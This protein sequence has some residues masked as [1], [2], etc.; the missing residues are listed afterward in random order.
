MCEAGPPDPLEKDTPFHLQRATTRFSI[1]KYTL[2]VWCLIFR[3]PSIQLLW[4]STCPFYSR[5]CEKRHPGQPHIPV[6]S[7]IWVPPPTLGW[8]LNQGCNCSWLAANHTNN[9]KHLTMRINCLSLYKLNPFRHMFIGR[10]PGHRGHFPYL[11]MITKAVK[12]GHQFSIL[13]FQPDLIK[14]FKMKMIP[15][16]IQTIFPCRRFKDTC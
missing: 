7:N 1:Q 14:H 13:E 11:A 15:L 9:H 12:L 5:N 10:Y 2:L 3:D 4:Y 6:P 8:H 16:Y